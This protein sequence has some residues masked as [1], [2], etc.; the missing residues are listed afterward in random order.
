MN[1]L[2]RILELARGDFLERARRS[3]F[4]LTLGAAAGLAY[5]VHAD[6]W[7]VMVGSSIPE[8]GPAW[9]GTLVAVATTIFLSLAAFYVVR[10]TIDRDLRTGVGPILGATPTTR[11]QYAASKF[12]SNAA[13]LGAM[14]LVVAALAV[15]IEAARAG[16]ISA[17]GV[18]DAVSPSLLITGPCLAAAAGAAVLFDGVP[19][20]RG[21]AGNVA[22]FFVWAG[23]LGFADIDAGSAWMDWTGANLVFETLQEALLEAHPGAPASGLTIS[24][25]DVAG[26]N[27]LRFPWMG[28][29]WT[30]GHLARR[31]WWVGV[32]AGLTGAAALSLRI[33]AP[34]RDRG[35]LVSEPGE[36]GGDGEMAPPATSG[37]DGSTFRPRAV[38]DDGA[39]APAGGRVSGVAPRAAV[40]ELPAPGRAGAFLSFLRTA[41]AELRLLLGGHPW[42]W[43]AGLAGVNVAALLVPAESVAT[44]LLVAWLLPLSAWSALGCRERLDGTEELLFSGP[45]PRLR[46]LPAQLAAG[47]GVSVVAGSVPLAR[48]AYAG[49]GP[50][51]L[52]AGVGALFVP[53]LAL[54]LGAWT[55]KEKTFHGVYLTVWYLGPVHGVG[56]LDFLGVADAVHL[57]LVYLGVLSQEATLDFMG[58]TERALE[59]GSPKLFLAATALLLPLAWTGRGRRLHAVD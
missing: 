9:T 45:S 41:G 26:P 51:L 40:S 24:L 34:F 55:G 4:L 7:T 2:R 12:L 1:P 25:E 10:G 42:W 8:P 46:Q 53:A 14:L 52:A 48:M 58:V 3:G 22:Y 5:T 54:C 13:V 37:T 32:G 59:A 35:G 19:W 20:L 21:V 31:L 36:K 11:L 29:G 50:S 27:A 30:V 44:P 18:W 49:N 15:G 39:P 28:I 43:Y 23:L 33:F 17:A 38:A 6:V 56:A 57:L 47:V 16:G